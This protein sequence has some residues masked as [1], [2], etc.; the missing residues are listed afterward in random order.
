MSIQSVAEDSPHLP[1]LV[2]GLMQYNQRHGG[3]YDFTPLRLV[4]LDDSGQLLGGLIAT[5]GWGWLQVDVLW[6]TQTQRRG[7]IGRALMS[8][9][10][11]EAKARGCVGVFLDTFDF[12]ARGFY[13]RLGFELFGTLDGQPAGHQRYWL[14]KNL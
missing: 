8:Q 4:R 13:E 12:Q 7:G 3:A 14:R 5:S 6:V 9:A 2:Q 11:L 1:A 10:F